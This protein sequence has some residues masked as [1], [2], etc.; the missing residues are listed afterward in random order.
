M[1][2]ACNIGKVTITLNIPATDNV[3]LDVYDKTRNSLISIANARNA[4]I[5]IFVSSNALS[6]SGEL[7]MVLIVIKNCSPG[8]F[9]FK[10]ISTA[11]INGIDFQCSTFKPNGQW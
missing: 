2:I 8:N 10:L 4:P 7:S 9:Y 3:K 5:V 11:N 1:D 6:V